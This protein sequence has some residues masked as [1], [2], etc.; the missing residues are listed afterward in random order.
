[1]VCAVLAGDGQGAL[2]SWV[3]EIR[4]IS[5]FSLYLA[6]AFV[7]STGL[8]LQQYRAVVSLITRLHTRWPNLTRLVLAHRNILITWAN[9]RPLVL[10]LSLLGVNTLASQLVWPQARSFRVA[11]LVVIWPVLPVVLAC[12]AAM[13]MFDMVGAFQVGKIDTPETEKY[14]DLAESW[15]SGWKAPVVRIFTLG[16][17][18]PRQMVAQEVRSALEGASDLLN[19]TLWWVTTQT[20]LRIACGL[21]L[22]G[23]YALQGPIQHLLGTE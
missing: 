14:F 20:V 2:M 12:T 9:L 11:D 15:L 23:S 7:L 8:R 17:V 4:P 22:W 16:Y 10:V 1:M 5:L 21:S 6:V 18:N 13:V 3:Y 19:S